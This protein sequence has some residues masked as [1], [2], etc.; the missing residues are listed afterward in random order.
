VWN[1][2]KYFLICLE[3]FTS[4]KAKEIKFAKQ[5]MKEILFFVTHAKNRFLDSGLSESNL[6]DLPGAKG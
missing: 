2:S 3:N 1:L 6:E 5:I 4:T